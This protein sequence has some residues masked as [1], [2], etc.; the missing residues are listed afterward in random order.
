M[1][2]AVGPVRIGAGIVD[3][4]QRAGDRG[5]AGDIELRRRRGRDFDDRVAARALRQ[6]A[7]D[8]QRIVAAEPVGAIV[9]LPWVRLPTTVPIAAQR[10]AMA[11]EQDRAEQRAAGLLRSSPP[12]VA[13][14]DRWRCRRCPGW[15]PILMMPPPGCRWLRC[16]YSERRCPSR[17]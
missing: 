3:D 2:E 10:V 9:A 6:V 16:T 4:L 12:S 8:L 14:K 17:R 11:R 13:R 7:G 5:R 1:D 15:C